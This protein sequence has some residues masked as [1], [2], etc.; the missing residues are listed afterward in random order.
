MAKTRGESV[1]KKKVSRLLGCESHQQHLRCWSIEAPDSEEA[2]LDA[3]VA[4]I[5]KR[6]TDDLEAWKKVTTEY[7][8]D[9]FCALYLERKNRGASLSPQTMS[10][11][12]ARGIEI[13]FD[14]YAP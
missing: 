6:V 11:L 1:D 3:Q 12:G 7:R 4:C 9:L 8:V 13:G 14:I 5:L 2:D 10:A